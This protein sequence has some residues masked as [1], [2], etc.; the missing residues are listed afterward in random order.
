MISRCALLLGGY[1]IMCEAASA[2]EVEEIFRPISSCFVSFR[3]WART[4]DTVEVADCWHALFRVREL[5]WVDFNSSNVDVSRCIDMLEY[6]HYDGLANG[7]LHTIVPG[8]L[9]ALP[10]PVDLSRGGAT[11]A[12]EGGVRRF[13]AAY[14]ADILS[15]LDVCLVVRCGGPPYDTRALASLRIGVEDLHII[16]GADPYADASAG[17]L[18]AADRFLTLAGLAPGAIALHGGGRDGSLGAGGRLLAETYLIR[19]HGFS[20]PAALAW[21]VMAHPGPAARAA[22]VVAAEETDAA[23]LVASA[24]VAAAAA[25]ARVGLVAALLLVGVAGGTGGPGSVG[26]GGW[27]RVRSWP[28]GRGGARGRASAP[29]FAR[30]SSDPARR[31]SARASA[32][33]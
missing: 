16:G 23:V 2:T 29:G 25:A 14:Y 31:A 30:S 10:C 3:P 26:L 17:L 9:I 7:A 33:I 5:G 20:G 27:E 19:G 21:L 12:D 8:K 1:L 28:E 11:W 24:A 15:E 22:T 6:L 4:T 18:R 13:S 32:C